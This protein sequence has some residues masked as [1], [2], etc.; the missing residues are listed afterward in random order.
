METAN[1]ERLRTA[2]L[3]GFALVSFAANSVLCRLALGEGAI[4]A[5]TFSTLRF[6]SGAAALVTVARVFRKRNTTRSES[7]WTSPG[8]LFVYAVTFSFAYNSLSAGTGALILFGLAQMTMILAGICWGLYSLKGQ[9]ALDPWNENAGNF[10]RCLPLLIAV[11]LIT[12]PGF[13]ISG[14][15]ALLAVIS[16][17]VASGVGYVVSYAVLPRLTATRAATLQLTVPLLAALA[18]ILFLSETLSLRVLLSASMILGG[19]GLAVASRRQP[20]AVS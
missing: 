19:V 1:G 17:A 14:E 15:G 13:R 5:A 8:V 7:N 4:D 12:L 20:Q 18:G 16:G 6:A 3:T 9:I 11:N 10:I 2:A